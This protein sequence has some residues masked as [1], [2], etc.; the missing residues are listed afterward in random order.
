MMVMLVMVVGCGK[1]RGREE[2]GQAQYEGL[3]HGVMLPQ[4]RM[5]VEWKSDEESREEHPMGNQRVNGGTRR[6]ARRQGG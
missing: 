5:D 6:R 1:D 4:T 2:Q 3:L